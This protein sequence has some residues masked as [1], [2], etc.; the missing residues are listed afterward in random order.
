MRS[1]IRSLMVPLLLLPLWVAAA[2]FL[3]GAP[4]AVVAASGVGATLGSALLIRWAVPPGSY[5]PSGSLWGAQYGRVGAAVRELERCGAIFEGAQDMLDVKRRAGLKV[6]F[7]EKGADV[8]YGDLRSTGWD[9]PGAA[10]R[11]DFQLACD[12]QPTLSTLSN[13]A[14]PMW[15]TMYV[16]PAVIEVLFTP[17]RAAEICGEKKVGDWLM[18]TA[19]FLYVESTGEVSSYGDYNENGSSGANVNFPQRQSYHYQ[20][21]TKWGEKEIARAGL[22]RL[23]WVSRL[24]IASAL[25]LNKF[26]NNSYF[27]GVAGLEN[28][29]LLNDPSLSA[30]LSPT[31]A[32]STAD[33]DVIYGDFV[34]M[35][36]QLQVQSQG[37][38]TKRDR[39]KLV[40]SPT[41]ETY[42][43]NT[44]P[45][46]DSQTAES[47]IRKGFPNLEIINA[48]EYHNPTGS[49]EF[50]QLIV[51]SVDGQK[52]AQCGFTEKM[53]AHAIVRDT[54]SWKQKKSQG[55]WG[56]VIFNP[57]A[58]VSMVGIT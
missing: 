13:S 37:V 31:S 48:V 16:D 56:T 25:A 19:Q 41:V 29:G 15:L 50:V 14:V 55:T 6:G 28:Y 4:D 44:N 3:S 32:W 39:M 52:T 33:A 42:L 58:I 57:F 36:R 34:R 24:N 21:F 12:A 8:D 17:M 43:L 46:Y 53:R 26:Q 54:S 7:R 49:G 51:E 2:A 47:L 30:A 22:A 23:D 27:F 1:V 20:T 38:I 10:W 40:L 18:D 9:G 5:L 45:P 11:N 35:F